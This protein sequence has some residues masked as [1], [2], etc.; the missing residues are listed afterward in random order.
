MLDSRGKPSV[1]CERAP[2]NVRP[3]MTELTH[4]YEKTGVLILSD[5]Y[6]VDMMDLEAIRVLANVGASVEARLNRNDLFA[7]S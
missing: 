3:E 4:S 6:A 2:V 1:A 5:F 7:V